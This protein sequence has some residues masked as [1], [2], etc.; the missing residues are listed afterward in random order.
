LENEAVSVELAK[1]NNS[2]TAI[3]FILDVVPTSE[4][5]SNVEQKSPDELVG[6]R[7]VVPADC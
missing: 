2:T 5:A 1:V 4:P 7:G 6:E 3:K